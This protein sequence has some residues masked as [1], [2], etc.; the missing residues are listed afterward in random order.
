MKSEMEKIS[1]RAGNILRILIEEHIRTGEPVGSRL[2]SKKFGAVLSSATVR[3]VMK[4]LEEL[5]FLWQPH[6]SAGRVPTASAIRYY[7]SYLMKPKKLDL[8]ERN[9][10][11]QVFFGEFTDLLQLLEGIG[12]ILAALSNELG[13]II[14]PTGEELILHKLEFI[15]ITSNRIV[16]V[17]ITHS[18]LT[19]SIVMEFDDIN[20]RKLEELGERVNQRLSGLTFSEI[21]REIKI[22]LADLNRLYGNFTSKL[23]QSAEEIFKLEDEITAIFGREN[24]IEKPEFADQ[25]Q[26]GQVMSACESDDVLLKCLSSITG[27]NVEIIVG[28]PQLKDLG[29]IVSTYPLGSGKGILGIIGPT[30]MNYARLIE[31]VSY[32]ARKMATLWQY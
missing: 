8:Q 5:G 20:T 18:G 9:A 19:R 10:I 23:I 12:K 30:R 26:L 24:I 7:I 17:L 14:A 21:K 2:I 16:V 3:N 1:Q 6:T 15:P 13:L 11:E 32:T 28:P 25:K 4:D 29:M 31:L 27:E 22:R